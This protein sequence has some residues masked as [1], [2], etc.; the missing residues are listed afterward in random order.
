[1]VS[2][3]QSRSGTKSTKTATTSATTKPALTLAALL[4][5]ELAQIS[6]GT[7][8]TIKLLPDLIEVA[9]RQLVRAAL[10]RQLFAAI[11]LSDEIDEL[12]ARAAH[13][14]GGG[15]NSGHKSIKSADAAKKESKAFT[16][17]VEE[18]REHIGKIDNP[19]INDHKLVS[20][21]QKILHV[22]I[23]ALGTAAAHAEVLGHRRAASVLHR[24][25]QRSEEYDQQLTDLVHRAHDERRGAGFS[26]AAA[27][28]PGHSVDSGQ[29]HGPPVA[30]AQFG[31]GLRQGQEIDPRQVA[32]GAPPAP[33]AT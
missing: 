9:S 21:A 16:G 27:Q 19:E 26:M 2:Q 23:A 22:E 3:V 7:R 33:A 12:L 15:Q 4:E 6:D 8:K 32:H 25:V 14:T 17:L 20:S 1:M 31:A 11:E 18:A 28:Q 24:A 5:A 30:R 10:R 29:H 13:E